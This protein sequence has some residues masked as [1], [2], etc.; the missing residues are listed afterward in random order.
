MTPGVKVKIRIW[1]ALVAIF[2]LGCVTGVALSGLYRDRVNASNPSSILYIENLRR[3]LNLTEEQT[4]Q[5][6]MIVDQTG[7]EYRRFR[8]ELKPRYETTRQNARNQIRTLLNPEQQ[9]EYNRL[10]EQN[11]AERKLLLE[12]QE[13]KNKDR[14]GS[15]K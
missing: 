12:R 1:S 11:D 6:Q 15:L 8:A 9:Q 2:I 14:Q 4:K 10:L 7:N 3:E 5:V 13:I